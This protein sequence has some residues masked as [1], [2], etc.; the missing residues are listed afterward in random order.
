MRG[1]I[2]TLKRLGVRTVVDLRSIYD[3][4]DDVK[5]VAEIAGLRYEWVPM[6]VWNPPT[7]EE[8]KKYRFMVFPFA[9]TMAD[10]PA[11]R[12]FEHRSIGV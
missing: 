5:S 4:T 7:D 6:S 2:S 9:D 1:G 8:A 10:V 12:G 11:A 3:Y